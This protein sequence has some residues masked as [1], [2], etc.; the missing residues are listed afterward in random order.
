MSKI[1]YRKSQTEKSYNYR[2]N[3]NLLGMTPCGLPTITV[4]LLSKY[5][6]NREVTAKIIAGS[7]YGARI[8]TYDEST[9]YGLTIFKICNSADYYKI[10]EA[11]K[12][13][14]SSRIVGT[15]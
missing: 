2:G 10:V 3:C 6:K 8:M 14:G 4:R 15:S 5:Y 9:G 11:T 1:S 13:V 7:P 12:I